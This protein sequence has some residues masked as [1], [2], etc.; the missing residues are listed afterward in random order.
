MALRM[1]IDVGL[2]GRVFT[3]SSK[4]RAKRSVQL[5]SVRVYGFSRPPTPIN[6]E[7]P[8]RVERSYGLAA[9]HREETLQVLTAESMTALVS[10]W[11]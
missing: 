4:A 9:L 5:R 7:S 2:V 6:A 10:I 11:C 1:A 3:A 8:K